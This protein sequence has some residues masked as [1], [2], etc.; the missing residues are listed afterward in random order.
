MSV[1]IDCQGRT[2]L[3]VRNSVIALLNNQLE[4]IIEQEQFPVS[5]NLCLLIKELENAMYGI[6]C[7]IADFIKN[8]KDAETFNILMKDAINRYQKKFP[9]MDQDRKQRLENFYQELLKY[10][11]ELKE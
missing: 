5:E 7:D 8:R 6:G 1:H 10:A 11:E 9:D 4:D 2:I 3:H